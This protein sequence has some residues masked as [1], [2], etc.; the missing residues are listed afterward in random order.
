MSALIDPK[1][2][3]VVETPNGYRRAVGV[4]AFSGRPVSSVVYYITT[5]DGKSRKSSC[6]VSTWRDWCRKNKAI[7]VTK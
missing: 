7:E 3:D 6:W 2:G 1:P 4:N 5:K